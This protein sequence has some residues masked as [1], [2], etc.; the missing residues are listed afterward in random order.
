MSETFLRVRKKNPE[1]DRPASDVISYEKAVGML[2]ELP[3]A[4]K[5]LAGKLKEH[6]ESGG[7][8]ENNWNEYSIITKEQLLNLQA[9]GLCSGVDMRGRARRG[10][11]G[12]DY[13]VDLDKALAYLPHA[14]RGQETRL[15]KEI[16][17]RGITLI[18]P[19]IVEELEIGRMAMQIIIGRTLKPAGVIKAVERVNAPVK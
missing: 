13:A 19:E 15:L 18:T 17:R 11:K 5:F 10:K 4:R 9:A 2:L 8:I 1:P 6:L 12:V 3:E 7:T 14:M 16:L